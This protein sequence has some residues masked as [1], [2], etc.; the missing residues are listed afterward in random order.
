MRDFQTKAL[1]ACPNWGGALASWLGLSCVVALVFVLA[2]APAQA[3]SVCNANSN[4]TYQQVQNHLTPTATPGGPAI[5]DQQGSIDTVELDLLV[6]SLFDSSTSS[7]G[8]ITITSIY[9][10]EDCKAGTQGTPGG[11][12]PNSP[13]AVAYQGNSS[14]STNCL[15][16]GTSGSTVSFSGVESNGMITFTASPSIVVTGSSSTTLICSLWF[17]IEKTAGS[18]ANSPPNTYTIEEDSGFT[19]AQCS[20]GLNASVIN[21]GALFESTPTPTPTNT[22]TNT[23][24]PTPTPTP[25]NTPTN[26]PTPTPT[27]TPPTPTSTPTVPP[28]PVPVVPS[29]TSPAGL[30]L[31]AGLAL[32]IAWM[33]GRMVRV[34]SPR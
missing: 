2:A 29:P 14:I 8:T 6:D 28:P 25:T 22:P 4:I 26:T 17:S 3:Q 24:T 20:N 11:C 12:T 33:L 30:I 32:S 18:T 31:I 9:F 16:N 15:S 1:S 13:L 5:P 10:D 23:P 7:Q 34:R 21:T 27:P 19:L